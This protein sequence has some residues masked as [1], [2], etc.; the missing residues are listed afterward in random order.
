MAVDFQGHAGGTDQP[1]PVAMEQ[2]H[3]ILPLGT[4]NVAVSAW[5]QQ[6]GV[7]NQDHTVEAVGGAV[8]ALERE[9]C[10][11]RENGGAV[12]AELDRVAARDVGAVARVAAS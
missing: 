9:S 7:G 10:R 5:T 6:A 12:D 2:D 8:V 4:A 11:A 1:L 3:R